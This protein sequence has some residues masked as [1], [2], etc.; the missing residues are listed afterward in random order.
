MEVK[1]PGGDIQEL[2]RVGGT[3]AREL[4]YANS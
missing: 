2:R 1:I 4:G 3:K